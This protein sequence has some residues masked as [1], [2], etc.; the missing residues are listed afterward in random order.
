MRPYLYLLFALLM[1]APAA[2]FAQ[3]EK[4]PAADLEFVKKTWP[5]AKRTSTG[6]WYVM[7]DEGKGALAKPGDMVSVHYVGWLING[8][9][10]DKV[11]Q[12]EPPLK[13]RLR[14]G[15]VIDG[16]YQG[17]QLMRPGCH[18]VLIVPSEMGY[19]SR[20]K[21]PVIPPDSTLVF[22]VFLEE[23]KP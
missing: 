11:M 19:G 16:W 3:R 15:N 14:E 20:G 2:A 4:L 17:V 6:L 23:A 7:M 13:F 5:N 18:L 10:F 22:E 12:P 9:M 1:V 21:I 8:T